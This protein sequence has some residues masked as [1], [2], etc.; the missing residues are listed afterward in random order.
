[1]HIVN[2]K[3]MKIFLLMLIAIS[4]MGMSLPMKKIMYTVLLEDR[5]MKSI[6]KLL[7]EYDGQDLLQGGSRDIGYWGGGSYNMPMII[8][9]I[10][11]V[12]WEEENGSQHKYDVPLRK[13]I[14]T[15]DILGRKF[16]ITFSFCDADLSVI[17]GK[18]V[19][20]FEYDEKEIWTSKN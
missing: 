3:R 16:R 10:A 9:K 4:T 20:Q 6:H 7:I 2:I 5:C 18:A 11:T 13:L 14:K 15:R 8:P 12:S 17:F 1:M 19:G